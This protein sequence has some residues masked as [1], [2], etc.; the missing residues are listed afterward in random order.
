MSGS[1]DLQGIVDIGGIA[2]GNDLTLNFVQLEFVRS[3]KPT[4]RS[5]R[6]VNQRRQAMREGHVVG[7][8]A[9]NEIRVG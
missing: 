3:D 2:N 1:R 8:L 7:I 6:R 5:I 4:T 9:C